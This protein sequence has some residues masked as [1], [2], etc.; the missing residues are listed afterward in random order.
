LNDFQTHRMYSPK[1][2]LEI[3]NRYLNNFEIRNHSFLGIS[4]LPED[5]KYLPFPQNVKWL[6]SLLASNVTKS[7]PMLTPFAD[8]IFIKA[9]KRS[10]SKEEVYSRSEFIKLHHSSD[11]DNL[12]VI[13]L[14]K[15]PISGEGL[16]LS[17]DRTKVISKAAGVYYPVFNDIPILIKSEALSL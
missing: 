5:L 7:F 13:R 9:N 17:V 16:Q 2:Y 14:A 8:S 15:C 11:F 6:L 3:F 10:S 1:E 12:N 4:I